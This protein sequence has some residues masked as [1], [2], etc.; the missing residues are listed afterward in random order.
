[1]RLQAL[2]DCHLRRQGIG[3]LDATGE[4]FS[5]RLYRD[6]SHHIG[7]ARMSRDPRD[8]VVD[9]QCA[10]HGVGNLFVA[11]SAVFPTSGHANP[12]LTIVALAIRLAGH[13]RAVS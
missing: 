9:E 13:L 3:R 6:A 10:V 11:G 7:T 2:L 8:G 4:D 12:T 5:D 1:M